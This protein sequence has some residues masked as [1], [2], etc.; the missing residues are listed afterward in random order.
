MDNFS[1]FVTLPTSHIMCCLPLF[2]GH[3]LTDGILIQSAVRS[4][5]TLSD[6]IQEK[7]FEPLSFSIL[8]PDINY[9]Q[10]LWQVPLMVLMSAAG[11]SSVKLLRIQMYCIKL[12]PSI[13]LRP[14]PCLLH[15][16]IFR[17]SLPSIS[18]S[19]FLS[20]KHSSLNIVYVF[21]INHPGSMGVLN[22]LSRSNC[23]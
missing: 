3:R 12:Y 1:G 17:L 4:K 13:N 20:L 9:C 18:A 10:S 7:S 2:F 23:L 21:V 11:F 19:L 6:L 16:V 14:T 22:W 5:W 8:H 15:S